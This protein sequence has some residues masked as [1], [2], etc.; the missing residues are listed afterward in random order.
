MHIHLLRHDIP[1]EA[2]DMRQ[3]CGA[4][5]LLQRTN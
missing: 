1:S 5:W 2:G 4:H 3:P